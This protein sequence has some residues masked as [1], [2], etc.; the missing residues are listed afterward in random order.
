MERPP[1][2]RKPI[3]P[4][5]AAVLAALE[6]RPTLIAD[7]GEAEAD[8][9]LGQGLKEAFRSLGARREPWH[10]YCDDCGD[11]GWIVVPVD[12]SRV[13][14][15]GSKS[16]EAIRCTACKYWEKQRKKAEERES[17]P[18]VAAGARRERTRR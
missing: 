18:F 12:V 9:I 6:M 4:F 10:Y 15:P 3:G 1:S 5:E 11:T 13:Y 2:P 7:V 14:G 8:R 17:D 16:T